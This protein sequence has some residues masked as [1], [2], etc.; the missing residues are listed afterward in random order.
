MM[1]SVQPDPAFLP[2]SCV[3]ADSPRF[4]LIKRKIS[5]AEVLLSHP[6][7]MLF[8]SA[9]VFLSGLKLN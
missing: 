3:S 1:L 2:I 5:P 4:P 7:R 8:L 6:D 9:A